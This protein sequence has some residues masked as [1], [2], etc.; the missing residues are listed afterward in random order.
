[1]AVGLTGFALAFLAPEI[2]AE[3]RFVAVIGPM[4]FVVGIIT[5]QWLTKCPKCDT[6]LGQEMSQKIAFT[7]FGKAPNFCPYCG[8]SL[9]EQCP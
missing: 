2:P 1:M 4:M 6:R 3:Y 8:I 9:D 7:F 5:V